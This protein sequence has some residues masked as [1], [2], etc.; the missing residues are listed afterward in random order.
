MEKRTKNISGEFIEKNSKLLETDRKKER[1]NGGLFQWL[2]VSYKLIIFSNFN[3]KGTVGEV[4]NEDSPI[5]FFISPQLDNKS[6]SH[7]KAFVYWN[8][9]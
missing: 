3:L 8:L 7:H 9:G 2:D 6:Y 5:I 1:R 4:L